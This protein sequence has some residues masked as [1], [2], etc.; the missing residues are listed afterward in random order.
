V[1][2][3]TVKISNNIYVCAIVV[4]MRKNCWL[5]EFF[6]I[7]LRHFVLQAMQDSISPGTYKV[8]IIGSLFLTNMKDLYLFFKERFF[9]L[10][11]FTLYC[12]YKK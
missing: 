1:F 4:D 6:N 9:S 12:D 2:K 3:G 8:F 7:T 5:N 11:L 10:I